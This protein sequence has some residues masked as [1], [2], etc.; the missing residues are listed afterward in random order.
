MAI[1]ATTRDQSYKFHFSW[2][3]INKIVHSV[4]YNKLHLRKCFACSFQQ[5]GTVREQHI[6][7]DDGTQVELVI[8]TDSSVQGVCSLDEYHCMAV[9]GAVTGSS[10]GSVLQG[11]ILRCEK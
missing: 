4:H 7:V 9:G 1:M 8:H 10:Q 3:I 6:H 5:K 11:S 2:C